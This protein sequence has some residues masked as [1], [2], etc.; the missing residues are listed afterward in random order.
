MLNTRSSIGSN[1][2]KDGDTIHSNEIINNQITITTTN[3]ATGR[4]TIMG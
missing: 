1:T 3:P 2:L 4:I